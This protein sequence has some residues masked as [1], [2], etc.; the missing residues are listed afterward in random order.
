MRMEAPNIV[1]MKR[2]IV[3]K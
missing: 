1:K 2:I 3:Q